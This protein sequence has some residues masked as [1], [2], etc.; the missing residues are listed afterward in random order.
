MN[1]W[2]RRPY[3]AGC[4]SAS[5]RSDEGMAFRAADHSPFTIHYSLYL[6]LVLVAS[7]VPTRLVAEDF[8]WSWNEGEKA[9]KPAAGTAD[10]GEQ[11]D[12][13]WEA[14]DGGQRPEAGVQRPEVRSQAPV[15]VDAAAYN[16]LL[17]ENLQ[18]RKQVA[19][20]ARLEAAAQK[21]IQEL[22]KDQRTLQAQINTLAST[23]NNLERDEAGATGDAGRV[24]ELEVKLAKAESAKAV[25]AGQMS[26]LK[27]ELEELRSSGS[28]PGPAEP[29]L[30]TTGPTVAPE[31]D[32]FKKLQEENALLKQQLAEVGDARV[33]AVRDRD[34]ILKKEE[35]AD[36]IQEQARQKQKELK[37]LLKAS[38][39]S[40]GEQ[41][42][43]VA[44]LL[45]RIPAMERELEELRNRAGSEE[46][47]R[48]ARERE[49]EN[50]REEL[51]LREYRLTKAGRMAN[52]LDEALEEV[53]KVSDEQ[54]RDMHYN[55]AVVYAKEGRFKDAQAEYL[56]ALRID[57]ADAA[58]HYNLA[59]LYDDEL[60][61]KSRAAAHYRKY[62][63]L[64]PNAPDQNEVQ[65]W[66]MR[67]EMR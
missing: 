6:A 50:I 31:S 37:E 43:A 45:E 48:A 10:P 3:A 52:M 33:K 34:R 40:E 30:A 60:N 47:V 7:S 27:I 12:W 38:K 36:Q 26:E 16:E 62:L 20:K 64:N 57:P 5:C 32:L 9:G 53:R 63:Q 19:E 17:K 25:L 28:R 1:S 49:L 56:R 4:L 11:F 67:L 46:L 55:M 65:E 22:E 29:A 39:S 35:R 8:D 42:E 51:R 61:N 58:A 59:I 23:I 66:I 44:K 2:H 18:L 14:E 54:K 24:G 21:K 41:R 15:G 13:E